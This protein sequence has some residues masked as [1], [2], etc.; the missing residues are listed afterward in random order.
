MKIIQLPIL[1]VL[2]GITCFSCKEDKVEV[3]IDPAEAIL[4]KW[5]LIEI[6]NWPNMNPIDEPTGYREFMPDSI[7][8]DYDYQI[9]NSKCMKYSIDDEILYE[10]LRIPDGITLTFKHEYE[11][12]E[13]TNKLRLDLVYESALNSTQIFKKID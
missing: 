1:L 5:E 7:L 13:E 11:F 8:C 2:I 6:G 12:F 9:E 4:G 10:I 3:E